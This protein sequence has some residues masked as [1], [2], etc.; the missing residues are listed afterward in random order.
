[1]RILLIII[2]FITNHVYASGD[3]Y[4]ELYQNPD[5]AK[6]I[7][8]LQPD[9]SYIGNEEAPITMITYSSLSCFHCADFYVDVF[10]KIKEVF[11]DTGKV[12]YIHRDFPSDKASLKGAALV[13]CADKAK[14]FVFLKVLFEK[15]SVWAGQKN[16]EE[17]LENIGKLGGMSGEQIQK[18]LNDKDVEN[19]ILTKRMNAS[20]II[21][22]KDG[23]AS[24]G[25]TPCFF[26]NGRKYVGKMDFES[27]EVEIN[28]SIK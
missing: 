21:D 14:S 11:I 12:K 1:M 7:L 10:P 16:Y 8:S 4:H 26:I 15:Q 2:M 9:D 28:S 5:E 20:K 3:I 24:I 13:H 23:K 27:I 17:I 22:K 18:C 6:Q 25:G 19:Q